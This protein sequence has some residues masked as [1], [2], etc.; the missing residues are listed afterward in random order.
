MALSSSSTLADALAQYN[1][2]LSWQGNTAKA[3]LALEAIRWLLVNRARVISDGNTRLDF[4]E[5]AEEKRKLEEYVASSGTSNRVS[6][7][8]GRM[9][10]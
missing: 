6:F 10:T 4:S 3:A 7:T 9:L 1:D 5:L 8:R 2:N